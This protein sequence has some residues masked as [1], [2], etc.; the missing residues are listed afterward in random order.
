MNR[1]D[2]VHC[3]P[4]LHAL[5]VV[6]D[7]IAR[8]RLELL[9]LGHAG[10]RVPVTLGVAHRAVHHRAHDLVGLVAPAAEGIGARLL[11]APRAFDDIDVD[12]LAPEG[13]L[14]GAL[15]LRLAAVLGLLVAFFGSFA[16][17][18]AARLPVCL[19]YTSPSPRDQRGSRMPSSA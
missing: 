5:A 9:V 11:L 3:S 4:P 10:V 12:P 13:P 1:R 14:C 8:N 17:E 6:E 16:S 18:V 2:G 15:V 19:L 7:V